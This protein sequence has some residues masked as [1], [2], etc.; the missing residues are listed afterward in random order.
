[1]GSERE[2]GGAVNKKIIYANLI[3]IKR[4]G[5]TRKTNKIQSLLRGPKTRGQNNLDAFGVNRQKNCR[6]TYFVCRAGAI[7]NANANAN[8]RV[9]A[10]TYRISGTATPIELKF[11][12]M[13]KTPKRSLNMKN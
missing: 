6:K 7:A 5:T 2:L 4:T 11:L 1:M 3:L 10:Q 13:L 12:G 9:R 8:A